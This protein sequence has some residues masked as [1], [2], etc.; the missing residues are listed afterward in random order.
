MLQ[1]VVI[2]M[3]KY[4]IFTVHNLV[5]RNFVNL[6]KITFKPFHQICFCCARY[7]TLNDFHVVVVHEIQEVLLSLEPSFGSYSVRDVELCIFHHI[8]KRHIGAELAELL[9]NRL[10]IEFKCC[11]V[12]SARLLGKFELTFW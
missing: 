11:A 5:N 6:S 9:L 4:N 7:A 12:L 1:Q 3:V 10:Y 2:H 8:I